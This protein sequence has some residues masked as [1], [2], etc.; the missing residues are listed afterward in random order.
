[1][2]IRIGDSYTLLGFTAEGIEPEPPPQRV[3]IDVNGTLAS[4]VDEIHEAARPYSEPVRSC[5]C[6]YIVVVGALMILGG[7][8][9]A[10]PAETVILV[11]VVVSILIARR[12]RRATA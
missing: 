3:M 5:C 1:M 12:V 11:V 10:F 7:L 6:L 4:T 8:I 2:Y 9:E